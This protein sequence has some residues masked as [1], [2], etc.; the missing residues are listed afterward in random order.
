[1]AWQIVQEYA[2]P[3]FSFPHLGH[4]MIS[5]TADLNQDPRRLRDPTKRFRNR[6]MPSVNGVN[7]T[8]FMSVERCS[9]FS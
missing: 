5:L 4:W 1:M 2:V 6:G 7:R 3:E 9:I 8:F